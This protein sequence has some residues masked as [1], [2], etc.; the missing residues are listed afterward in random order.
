MPP[1]QTPTRNTVV[2][3]HCSQINPSS[4]AYCRACGGPL[5]LAWSYDVPLVTNRFMLKDMAVV[6]GLSLCIMVLLVA[7][8]SFLIGEE[9][10]WIPIQMIGIVAAVLIVLFLIAAGVVLGNRITMEFVLTPEGVSWNTGTRQKKINR[11]GLILATLAGRPGPMGAS[12]LAVASESGGLRWRDIHKVSIFS[13]PGVIT[14]SNSWRPVLRLY[15]PPSLQPTVEAMVKTYWIP[16]SADARGTAASRRNL[17]FLG[18]RLPWAV[19][20][21]AACMAAVAWYDF[22]LD[23]AWRFLIVAGILVTAASLFGGAVRRILGFLGGALTVYLLVGHVLEGL[24]PIIGPSGAY[25]GRTLEVDPWLFAVSLV[26]YL[27]LVGLAV[28]C[29]VTGR[30]RPSV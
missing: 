27:A 23:D 11:A 20:A 5:T 9:I 12:L 13:G 6:Y 29:V 19:A 15:A 10:V 26:G 28:R 22:A 2:C 16:Q 4:V 17:R 30:P 21:V 24:D 3:P 14:L 1:T 18:R 25:Y 8:M 7:G